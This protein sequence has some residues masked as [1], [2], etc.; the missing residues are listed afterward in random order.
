MEMQ[1]NINYQQ[2]RDFFFETKMILGNHRV[3]ATNSKHDRIFFEM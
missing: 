2:N 3:A 1:V